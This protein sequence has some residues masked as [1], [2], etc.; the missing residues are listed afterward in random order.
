MSNDAWEA[1]DRTFLKYASKI[2]KGLL[3]AF[4]LRIYEEYLDFGRGSSDR[5]DA[6]I[7]QNL[8]TLGHC[9]HI[10][11]DLSKFRASHLSRCYESARRRIL[12]TADLL[13][14]SCAR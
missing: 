3:V 5:F 10:V 2:P 6:R 14:F 1:A 13:R 12:T 8:L 4:S 9:Y 7:A 11:A